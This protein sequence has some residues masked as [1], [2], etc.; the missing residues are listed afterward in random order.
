MSS[1]KTTPTAANDKLQTLRLGS[2]VRCTDDRVEGRIVWANG[3]CVKIQW[4]DGEQVTWRRDYLAARPIEILDSDDDVD[5][6]SPAET[7]AS[8]PMGPTEPATP[9]A[10]QTILTE[11]ATLPDEAAPAPVEQASQSEASANDSSVP[12]TAPTEVAPPVP[13]G[14]ATAQT[15]PAEPTRERK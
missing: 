7:P 14:N 3:L 6:G 2:R 4:D 13:D 12:T 5:Q 1:K 10:E 15:P 9:T 8:A 11:P